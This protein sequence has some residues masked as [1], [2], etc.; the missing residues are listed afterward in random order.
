[1]DNITLGK[2]LPLNSF[3]HRLDPRLKLVSL[4]ILLITIFFNIGFIGYGIMA[5]FVI[6]VCLLSKI[7]IQYIIKSLKPMIFMIFFLTFFNIFFIRTGEVAFTIF[8]FDIYQDALIQSAKIFV[9]IILIIA[10]TTILTAS[11]KPLDLTLA[12]ESL[13]SP[14]KR[15]GFP[16]HELAMMISIS[17]RFI[18]DLLEETKRIMKA[19]ASRGV[20]FNEGKLKEKISAIVSLIIPLFLSSFQRAEDLANAMES[21]NYNPTAKRTRYQALKWQKRDTLAMFVVIIY[22]IFILFGGLYV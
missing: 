14:L 2:Y 5:S 18:P 17:L 8:D 7:S 1:M 4:F 11:S 16:S 9:R 6:I 10:L 21:R 19:Q 13:L 3:I 15:F 20:D 22:C 12:I